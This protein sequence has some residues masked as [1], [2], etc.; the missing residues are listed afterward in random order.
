MLKLSKV[1]QPLL[2]LGGGEEQFLLGILWDLLK[3]PEASMKPHYSTS[4]WSKC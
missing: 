1:R 2:L 3:C 4:C